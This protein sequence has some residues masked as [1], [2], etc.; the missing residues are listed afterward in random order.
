MKL[1]FN[2]LFTLV[3]HSER[4]I[5]MLYADNQQQLVEKLKAVLADPVELRRLSNSLQL[6]STASQQVRSVEL[7]GTEA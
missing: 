6:V 3:T 5:Q 4:I 7:I 1:T 2:M